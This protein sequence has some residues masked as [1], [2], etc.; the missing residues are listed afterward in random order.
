MNITDKDTARRYQ[1]DNITSYLLTSEEATGAKRI[2]TS[3]VEMAKG[4]KQHIH[5][6]ET[7]QCYFILE[8]RGQMTVGDE[9]KE[10]TAGMSV[11]VP[12]NAPHGLVNTTEGVLRYLSAGSPPFGRESELELWPLFPLKQ[13]KKER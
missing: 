2:T 7:E 10:V 5:A 12:S 8:G 3:L 4:G 11:F 13:S 9:S 1:R 6:H